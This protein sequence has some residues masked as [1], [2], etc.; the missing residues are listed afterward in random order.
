MTNSYV[1]WFTDGRY[2]YAWGSSPEDALANYLHNWQRGVTSVIPAETY[3]DALPQHCYLPGFPNAEWPDAEPVPGQP[4]YGSDARPVPTALLGVIPPSRRGSL[5]D[6]ATPPAP[7]AE[8]S[9][10]EQLAELKA[11]VQSLV[12]G[13]LRVVVAPVGHEASLES[14][15]EPAADA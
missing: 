15:E 8:P 6:T 7:P 1:I 3:L 13:G 14:T 12:E 9:L 2:A 11:Q 5:S 4:L 10:A